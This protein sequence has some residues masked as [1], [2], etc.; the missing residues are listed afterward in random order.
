MLHALGDPVRLRLLKVYSTGR[1]AGCAPD[2]LGIPYL[3]KPTI[4]HHL[5]I[6][7]EVG[8]VSIR[9]AGR[10]RYVELRRD[11]LDTRFPGL[12][13]TVLKSLPYQAVSDK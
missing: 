8:L 12:L 13:D 1:Q 6:M 2:A 5:K 11:D 7:R 4:S 3:Q 10:N 9:A